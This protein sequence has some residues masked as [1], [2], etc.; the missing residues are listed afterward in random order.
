MDSQYSKRSYEV[1]WRPIG[2]PFWETTVSEPKKGPAGQKT[3]SDEKL[4][5]T[6]VKGN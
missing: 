1:S 4:L 3:S 5:I 2:M 6:K